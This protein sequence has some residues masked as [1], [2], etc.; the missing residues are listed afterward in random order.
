MKPLATA[1]LESVIVLWLQRPP[2][3]SATIRAR[4]VALGYAPA[5]DA[6]LRLFCELRE[7]RAVRGVVI[8]LDEVGFVITGVDDAL[9]D[10]ET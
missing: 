4:L 3:R 1:F 6:L 8:A 2:V 9:V 10:E 7:A 5:D